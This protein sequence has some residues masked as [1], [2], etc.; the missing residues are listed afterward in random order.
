MEL[1]PST[2][3]GERGFLWVPGAPVAVYSRLHKI[4]GSYKNSYLYNRSVILVISC[5]GAISIDST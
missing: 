5:A 1:N 4:L 3:T 2:F